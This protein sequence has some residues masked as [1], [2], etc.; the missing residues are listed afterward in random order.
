MRKTHEEKCRFSP[1]Q[2]L[3]FKASL[4]TLRYSTRPAPATSTTSTANALVFLHASGGDCNL[5]PHIITEH[6]LQIHNTKKFAN[7]CDQAYALASLLTLQV[8]LDACM[9][10]QGVVNLDISFLPALSAPTTEDSYFAP[11]SFAIRSANFSCRS[12]FLQEQPPRH[13]FKQG[14][15]LTVHLVFGASKQNVQGA[16]GH[17]P[18][19][20]HPSLRLQQHDSIVASLVCFMQ[21]RFGED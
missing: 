6:A 13:F 15:A 12:L 14:N 1:F 18:M 20:V 9:R 19:W 5:Q 2:N 10:F 3:C 11:F 4:L 17:D 8:H 21:E 16:G 7:S